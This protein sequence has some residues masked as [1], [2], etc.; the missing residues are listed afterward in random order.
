LV[1]F[2]SPLPGQSATSSD[3]P[4]EDYRLRLYHTHTHERLNV[5]YRR[6][7]TYLPEALD[8]LDHFLACVV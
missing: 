5:V 8:Q 1:I 7:D 4:V 2:L 3:A 6:G